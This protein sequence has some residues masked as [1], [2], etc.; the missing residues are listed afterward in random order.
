MHKKVK[1][2]FIGDLMCD[3]YQLKVMSSSSHS[4]DEIFAE[5]KD[6]FVDSDYVV[7]NLETPIAGSRFGYS[8][9]P[10]FFN[11]PDAFAEAIKK[12]GVDFVTTA[13]NHCMDRGVDGM[14]VTL[15][16]LDRIG[17]KHTGTYLNKKDSE[18]IDVIEIGK[19]RIAFVAATYGYNSEDG[20]KG[21]EH[22]I[23]SESEEWRIDLLKQPAKRP[24]DTRTTINHVK[25]L[26]RVKKIITKVPRRIYDAIKVFRYGLPQLDRQ[27]FIPASFRSD[28]VDENE[29][30]LLHNRIRL[31][32]FLNKIKRAKAQADFVVVLPHVGGQYNPSPGG[33]HKRII[34]E[35]LD[36]GADLIV[37]NH[38]HNPLPI[39]ETKGVLVANSLGNFCCTPERE[40]Y[41]YNS[42]ADYGV[43][44]NIYLDVNTK[45]FLSYDYNIVKSVVDPDG[46][47]RTL[48]VES[49]LERCTTAQERDKL[50]CEL[51]AV[52]TMLSNSYT[53]V[54]EGK[55]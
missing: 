30:E 37:A 34:R 9:M 25:F 47:S 6:V 3:P 20:R 52:K 44:L 16:T 32:R 15:K 14:T 23:L 46:F 45:S 18:Q 31:N 50:Q 28:C 41:V 2:S 7:G 48:S 19:V 39:F 26:D 49:V 10:A 1:V 24:S 54:F 53:P 17:L 27:S 21:A 38:S 42:L 35:I 8:T 13:N 33:Y 29:F 55:V 51:D 43:V 22:E 4:F 40:W 12:L 5:V 11:T 36:N